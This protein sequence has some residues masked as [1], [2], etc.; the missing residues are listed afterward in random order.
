MRMPQAGILKH[1]RDERW[2]TVRQP[3]EL[4]FE[5]RRETVECCL[6]ETI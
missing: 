5:A 3:L 1:C 4:R 6:D 2:R